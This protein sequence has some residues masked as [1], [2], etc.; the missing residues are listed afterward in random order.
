MI[1]K[2]PKQKFDKNLFPDLKVENK[3]I[4]HVTSCK[5]LG[6][7]LDEDLSFIIHIDNILN[8]IRKLCG[9][10]YK[11]RYKLPNKCL[12][13]LYFALVH[14]HLIYCLEMYG[15]ASQ[16][17]LEPLCKVNNKI[18]RILQ[19]KPLMSNVQNLYSAYNTL[20]IF[21]IR[22]LKILCLVH[23]FIH[24][25]R[26]LP[27]VYQNYFKLNNE[28]HSHDTRLKKGLHMDL[29][30]SSYGL[31]SI[32]IQGCQLWNDLPNSIR[33][34]QSNSVFKKRIKL[35]LFQ[36]SFEKH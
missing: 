23:K 21:A 6:V 10:F 36:K 25:V 1:F 3:I 34:I 26:E 5:Y 33:N 4:S 28:V 7:T 2:K 9:A 12:K 17:R 18:L 35:I 11:L 29:A 13:N 22:K 14:S 27:I 20:P 24:H 31:K 32:R 16:T 15:G 8:K 30:N 19:N